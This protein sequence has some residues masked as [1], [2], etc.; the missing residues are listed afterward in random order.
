MEDKDKTVK[1][2][3]NQQEHHRIETF[4]KEYETF[5]RKTGQVFDE[6]DWNR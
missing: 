3:I 5:I 4:R 1:Y 6:R 2:I